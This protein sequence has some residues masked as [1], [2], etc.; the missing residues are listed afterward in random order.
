MS[1]LAWAVA[2]LVIKE[3]STL[4]DQNPQLGIGLKGAV[5]YGSIMLGK[6]GEEAPTQ[7]GRDHNLLQPF[8]VKDSSTAE[9]PVT[10]EDL[11]VPTK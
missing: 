10:L 6:Y 2:N 1:E 8:F 9:A 5:L 7:S 11:G 4:A 3:N